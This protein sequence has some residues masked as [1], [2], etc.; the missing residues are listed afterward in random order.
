MYACATAAIGAGTMFYHAS[1]T[2]WGQTIDVLGMYL[3]ASFIL[4]YNLARLR[5]LS[6]T[7]A[8]IMYLAA[9]IVLLLGLVALPAARRYVFAALILTAIVLELMSRRSRTD[10]ARTPMLA[11]ALITFLGGFL[12]WIADITGLLCAPR[13]WFQGH[14]VWHVL[15]ALAIWQMFLYLQSVAPSRSW[16]RI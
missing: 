12:M 1:L 3:I 14:A 10:S 8:S 16:S 5:P 4:L 9:N 11:A 13:S 15:S 2:F 7:S 6:I